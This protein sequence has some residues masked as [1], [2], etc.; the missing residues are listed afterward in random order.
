MDL[1]ELIGH[2]ILDHQLTSFHAL[3]HTV[4]VTKHML[5]ITT[6]STAATI[7]ILTAAKKVQPIPR[8]FY[9]LIELYVTFVRDKLVEPSLGHHT[10]K[11]LNYF[12]TL[13]LFILCNNLIGLVPGSATATAN[14]AVTASLALCTLFLVNLASI[15]EHGFIGHVKSF[16]PGGV[17]PA[18]VPLIF[19]LEVF[20]LLIRCFVLAV[21]LFANMV[22]GHAVMLLFFALVFLIGSMALAPVSIGIVIF[23]LFIELLVAFLQAYI[24]TMLSAIFVGLAVH[25]H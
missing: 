8:G 10:D 20:G 18:L 16:V 19:V 9:N 14:I 21:R 6:V 11:Y 23:I 17:P 13:F 12:L 7:S 4:P 15:R 1:L 3:G 24:F 5:V 25:S 22:A 2:H